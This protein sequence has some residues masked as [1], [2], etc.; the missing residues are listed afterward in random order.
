MIDETENMT[1]GDALEVHRRMGVYT[2][3]RDINLF[4][5]A[6]VLALFGARLSQTERERDEAR[7]EIERLKV[8]VARAW[9]AKGRVGADL[10]DAREETTNLR[11]YAQSLEYEVR[12]VIKVKDEARAEAARLRGQLD[13]VSA[14]GIKL[15]LDR[16]ELRRWQ[17]EAC[18]EIRDEMRWQEREP[19]GVF[20]RL[21]REAEEHHA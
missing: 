10:I 11:G 19:E 9:E 13:E 12:E 16:G 7:A 3:Q 6:R 1:V 8:E 20:A 15:A 17:Q 5:N 2:S 4:D 21:L 14:T 18:S